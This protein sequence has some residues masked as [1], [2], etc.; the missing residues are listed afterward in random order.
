[1]DEFEKPRVIWQVVDFED[2]PRRWVLE[3]EYDKLRTENQRLR[4]ALEIIERMGIIMI[5]C[6]DNKPG[7]LVAHYRYNDQAKK[8]KQALE[9][10]GE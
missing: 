5:P 1:M 8:A 7:C 3:T 9:G 6:P 10:E 4:E 2:F